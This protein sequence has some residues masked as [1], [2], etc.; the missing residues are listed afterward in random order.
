MSEEIAGA[1]RGFGALVTTGKGRDGGPVSAC[2]GSTT[3]SGR[4]QPTSRQLERKTKWKPIRRSPSGKK[5]LGN[6]IF[7]IEQ[8]LLIRMFGRYKATSG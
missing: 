8:G 3:S 5:N 6:P 2:N 1:W 7:L 4:R